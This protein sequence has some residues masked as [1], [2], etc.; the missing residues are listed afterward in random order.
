MIEGE[1]SEGYCR[2]I[3]DRSADLLRCGARLAGSGRTRPF[4]LRL[5]FSSSLSHSRSLSLHLSQGQR[6]RSILRI[7]W[8]CS[9]C[10]AGSKLQ[11]DCN[12]SS[13]RGRLVSD[14]SGKLEGERVSFR[15]PHQASIFRRLIGFFLGTSWKLQGVGCIVNVVWENLHALLVIAVVISLAMT[16]YGLRGSTWKSL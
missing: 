10:G 14:H 3:W 16:R 13:A 8:I 11:P 1:L 5:I 15:T 12:Y 7:T 4:S 9:I 2:I 6:F